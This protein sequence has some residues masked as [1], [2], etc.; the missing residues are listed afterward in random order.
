MMCE[1]PEGLTTR[2]VTVADVDP[3]VDLINAAARADTGMMGTNRDDK[4]Q[5]WGLPQFNMET[6][7]LLVLAPD[8]SAIGVTELWDGPPHV[9]HYQWGRVHPK[10]RGRGIGSY[11]LE[12]AERRARQS[13]SK[14]PPDARVSLHTSTVHENKAAHELFEHHGFT[15]SRR[16][17]WMLIEMTPEEPSPAPV[18][19]EGVRCRPFILGQDERATHRTLDAAFKDHWG[20]VQGESSEEWIHWIEG[21]PAFDPSMSFLAVTEGADGEAIAGALMARPEWEGD[22]SIAWVDELGV[23]RPWRQQGIALALL[24]QVFGA[25]HRRGR[26]KVGLGV[27]GAS[28]TGATRLYEKAGMHVFRQMDS[29]E[30]VLRPGEDLSTQSV[31]E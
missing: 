30:K 3:V 2:P 28:L 14:A 16:F 11:L 26:W 25:C 5:K 21:D 6:D 22:P 13:L 18:W 15:P 24:Q 8:G 9:R 19:P 7:T 12:W 23:L 27:D 31:E 20:Y 10:Y 4:L 1:I 17:F 29:Y